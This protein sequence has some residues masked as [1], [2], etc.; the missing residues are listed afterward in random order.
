MC[1]SGLPRLA[2][3]VRLLPMK[4]KTLADLAS[5]LSLMTGS[6]DEYRARY[7]AEQESLKASRQEVNELGRRLDSVMGE[8][9]LCRAS[10]AEYAF[11]CANPVTNGDAKRITDLQ[12]RLVGV[13][14]PE[15]RSRP[16][17]AIFQ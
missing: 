5:E 3:A 4:R 2:F 14:Y 6:R 9:S 1:F 8:L 17:G 12:R 13:S 15:T 11:A 7:Y 16:S 10:L